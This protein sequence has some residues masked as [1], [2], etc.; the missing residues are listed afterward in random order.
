MSHDEHILVT[1][2]GLARDVYQSDIYQIKQSRDMPVPWM[3]IETIN[4]TADPVFT[5]KSDVVC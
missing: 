4:P 3:A 2:F 5:I 1:D